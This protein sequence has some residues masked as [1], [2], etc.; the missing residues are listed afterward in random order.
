MQKGIQDEPLSEDIWYC[1]ECGTK[2]TKGKFCTEC[3][4][5]RVKKQKAE[6]KVVWAERQSVCMGDDCHA[7]HRCPLEYEENT[8][9]S[10]FMSTIAAYVPE[11]NNFTWEIRC[12]LQTLAYLIFDDK[13]NWT[14]ELAVA[15][16]KLDTLLDKYLDKELYEEKEIF[17]SKYK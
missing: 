2:H 16:A 6:T 8:L 11:M 1:T 4:T 14:Y 15:D 5:E 12:D 3:G 7:P 17:C 10:Q 9:L 13:G